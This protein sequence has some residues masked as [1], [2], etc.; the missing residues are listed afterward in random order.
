[1]TEVEARRLERLCDCFSAL[2]DVN[3]EAALA[4][5]RILLTAQEPLELPVD[6]GQRRELGDERSWL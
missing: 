2:T 5:S 1:M 6:E 4:V 3:K